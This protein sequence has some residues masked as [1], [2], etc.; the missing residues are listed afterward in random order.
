VLTLVDESSAGSYRVGGVRMDG[1]MPSC[2]SGYAATSDP[3]LEGFAHHL[4][5]RLDDELTDGER[6]F[7]T[8]IHIVGYVDDA[9]GI[10]PA[11]YFVRNPRSINEQ[12]GAYENI[13]D[14]FEVSEDFWS[15]DYK[16]S[17]SD[18]TR[19]Q[20]YFNGTPDGRVAFFH[21]GRMFNG[22]LQA[23]WMEPMWKFRPPQSLDELASIVELQIRTICILFVMS[24]YQAPLIGGEPQIQKIAPPAGAVTL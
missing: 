15:R 21:F 19:Y 3:S 13:A 17:L 12:T 23:I 18:K 22:F 2:I 7:A 20:S 4:K 14:T 24:D 8:L 1:W 5:E 6:T 10:H 16:H 9:D 11:F